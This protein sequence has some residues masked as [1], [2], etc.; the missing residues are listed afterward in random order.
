MTGGQ[1]DTSLE[2]GKIRPGSSIEGE[3]AHGRRVDRRTEFGRRQLDRRRFRGDL[4]G[5]IRLSNL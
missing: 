2:N 5:L 4:Y 3:F 1:N